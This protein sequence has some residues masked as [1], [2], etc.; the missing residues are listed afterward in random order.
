VGSVIKGGTEEKYIV[1]GHNAKYVGLIDMST[2]LQLTGQ[3]VEVEDINYMTEAET[4]ELVRQ[5]LPWAFSD[6]EF[7]AGGTK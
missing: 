5:Q 2:Y 3:P 7:D 4:R 1:F 6:Y